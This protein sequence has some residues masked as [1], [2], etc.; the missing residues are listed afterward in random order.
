V[1]HFCI[2]FVLCVV[3]EKLL[4]DLLLT[5][6]KLFLLMV[7]YLTYNSL[8]PPFRIVGRESQGMS[9]LSRFVTPDGA[10]KDKHG[11]VECNMPS[12]SVKAVYIYLKRR[13]Y[14]LLQ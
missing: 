12:Q 5:I 8:S 13:C 2:G 3:S 9:L 11:Y 14:G 1:S 4:N 10:H 6:D 7:I